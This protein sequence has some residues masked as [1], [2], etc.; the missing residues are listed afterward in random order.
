ML[1]ADST[2]HPTRDQ[3]LHAA[4]RLFAANG[5]HGTSMR[6]I[7]QEV[8]I[9]VGGIYNHFASKEAIYDA[10]FLEYHPY[11]EMVALL[12]QA[13]GDS[14]EAL[15]RD[16]ARLLSGGLLDRPDEFLKLMF[17]EIVEF[18]AAHIQ[19]LFAAIFPDLIRFTDR[20]A[21]DRE[22]LRDLPPLVAVRAFLGLFFSYFMTEWLFAAQMPPAA[23]DHALEHFVDIY[24]HG[25]LK[26]HGP[27][28][29]V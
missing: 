7:A 15:L 29:D 9:A 10:I 4:F 22:E 6:Q 5:F 25:I 20:L 26:P 13:Q 19:R 27:G 1:P 3:I 16:A 21:A 28:G 2:S 14:L 17:I 23:R 18:D 8:G 24:L 11:R 12:S